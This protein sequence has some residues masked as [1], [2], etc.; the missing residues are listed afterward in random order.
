MNSHRM[1]ATQKGAHRPLQPQSWNTRTPTFK[2]SKP[3]LSVFT[4]LHFSF[5]VRTKSSQR[6]SHPLPQ[7]HL[8]MRW[9]RQGACLLLSKL[10]PIDDPKGERL[11]GCSPSSHP[12]LSGLKVTCPKPV[13]TAW[14]SSSQHQC[15]ELLLRA[16]CV[17]CSWTHK[18]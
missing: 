13:N 7:R 6:S 11:Q 5:N 4:L 8:T 3:E 2:S 14:L 10:R 12:A 15:T 17:S 9:G 18:G 16:P 1:T